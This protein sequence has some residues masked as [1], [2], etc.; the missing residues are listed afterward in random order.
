ME[1]I[2]HK[3]T[4]KKETTNKARK[5]VLKKKLLGEDNHWETYSV[6]RVGPNEVA[7]WAIVRDFVEAVQV[8]DVV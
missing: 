6:L 1:A 5:K 3:T 8:A 4:K 7:D 2:H